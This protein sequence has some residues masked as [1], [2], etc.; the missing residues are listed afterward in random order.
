MATCKECIHS[1]ILVNCWI[2]KGGG[3]KK[4]KRIYELEVDGMEKCPHFRSIDSE[5]IL[6]LYVG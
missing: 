2:C 1:R 3:E 6:K 4:I 5:S